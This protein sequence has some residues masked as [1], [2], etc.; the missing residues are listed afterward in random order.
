MDSSERVTMIREIKQLSLQKFAD[1][2][3]ISRSYLRTVESGKS[4]PSYRML[5]ALTKAHGVNANWIING[6]GKM[7]LEEENS[8]VEIKHLDVYSELERHKKLV[9]QL[10]INIREAEKTVLLLKA[11]DLNLY[12]DLR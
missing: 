4:E 7:F 6:I 5:K 11:T 3:E 10:E 8:G 12:R 1:S 2:L 9:A